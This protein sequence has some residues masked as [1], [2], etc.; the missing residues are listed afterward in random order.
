M[1]FDLVLEEIGEFGKY[2]LTNYLLICLPVFFGAANS[3]S[4][5]FTAGVP[6]Y[7]S[8]YNKSFITQNHDA[9]NINSMRLHIMQRT[10]ILALFL[11]QLVT[12]YFIFIRNLLTFTKY[13]LKINKSMKYSF[14]QIIFFFQ[15]KC[16][17]FQ[18]DL[19]CITTALQFFPMASILR[20]YKN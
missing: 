9:L 18:R 7:R 17:N 20:S 8:V 5:V 13:S 11:S 16:F 15:C 6:N 1:D 2:Q 3:L 14:F 19:L 12:I 10:K 4:Y